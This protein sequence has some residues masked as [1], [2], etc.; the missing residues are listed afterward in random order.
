MIKDCQKEVDEWASQFNPKYWPIHEQLTRLC[1]ET[2]E[3]AREV[4]HLYGVKKKKSDEQKNDLGLELVDVIFTIC[5]IA[6]HK[7]IDLDEAWKE[8]MDKKMYGRDKNRF[9]KLQS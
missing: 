7:N 6:N 2:G 9:E 1:E 4:N 3:V 5:C 8:M